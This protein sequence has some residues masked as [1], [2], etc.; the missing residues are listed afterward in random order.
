LLDVNDAVLADL[1]DRLAIILPTQAS[2]LALMV[3]TLAMSRLPRIGFD[4]FASAEATRSTPRSM[5][6]LRSMGWWPAATSLAA[7]RNIACASTV[8]VVVPSPATDP[9]FDAPSMTSCAP[10]FANQSASSI[11]SATV[12]PSFVIKGEVIIGRSM[13][14]VRPPGPSVALTARARTRAPSSRRARP[15]SPNRKQLS[16]HLS[17]DGGATRAL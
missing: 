12:T 5:P 7:S 4:A 15:L 9:V 11:S 2:P 17:G 8:A 10:R 1:A 13:N 6:R 14:T 16:R 3:A